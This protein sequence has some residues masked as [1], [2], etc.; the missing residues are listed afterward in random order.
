ML[1]LQIHTEAQAATDQR[2]LFASP[3]VPSIVVEGVGSPR[4]SLSMS[5]NDILDEKRLEDGEFI[6]MEAGATE[7]T[8]GVAS[9]DLQQSQLSLLSPRSMQEKL[10]S[11]WSNQRRLAMMDAI[12]DVLK[13]E[14]R[15]VKESGVKEQKQQRNGEENPQ[16]GEKFD[17]E[18][19]DS[20]SLI[21]KEQVAS[22][23]CIV[24]LL[25]PFRRS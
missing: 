13:R 11:S 16:S 6:V 23:L 4:F 7:S 5:G 1:S 9:K 3:L 14:I 18:V 25:N 20:N 19:A 21:Q 8:K 24:L 12:M 2:A 10:L 17:T 22:F 15:H